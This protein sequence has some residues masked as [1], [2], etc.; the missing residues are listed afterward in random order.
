MVY[1]SKAHHYYKPNPQHARV[2]TFWKIYRT[3]KMV[4]GIIY[5]ASSVVLVLMSFDKVYKFKSWRVVKPW[6]I[7]MLVQKIPKLVRS[8]RHHMTYGI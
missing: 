4:I 7:A 3:I 5:D 2:R 8:L 1:R 6:Q